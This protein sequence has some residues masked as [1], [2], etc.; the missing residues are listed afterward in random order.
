MA[1]G[2]WT[3]YP[4]KR[5]KGLSSAFQLPEEVRNVQRDKHGVRR[6]KHGDKDEDNSPKN[7]NNAN[8]LVQ[9]LNSSS[10]VYF[11]QQLPLRHERL[12]HTKIFNIY[13]H[14]IHVVS[15]QGKNVQTYSRTRIMHKSLHEL[16]VCGRGLK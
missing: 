13:M 12:I 4:G 6:D 16:V 10:Q 11:Q 8:S 15:L 5:N 14:I 9:N 3:V 7:V 1:C 2:T